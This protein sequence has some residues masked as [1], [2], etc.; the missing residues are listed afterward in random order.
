MFNQIWIRHFRDTLEMFQDVGF[1]EVLVRL[2]PDAWCCVCGGGFGFPALSSYTDHLGIG[3]VSL[4][5]AVFPR[6]RCY[7][8]CYSIASAKPP[9]AGRLRCA[10]TWCTWIR[11]CFFKIGHWPR[12]NIMHIVSALPPPSASSFGG[13]SFLTSLLGGSCQLDFLQAEGGW[14]QGRWIRPHWYWAC[15]DAWSCERHKS[16]HRKC[17]INSR[18]KYPEVCSTQIKL[19]YQRTTKFRQSISLKWN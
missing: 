17:T 1:V 13:C 2:R 18:K 16:N 4:M 9:F 19:I 7:F 10:D 3:R 14:I 11:G 5:T 6:N 8:V 15:D 12:N